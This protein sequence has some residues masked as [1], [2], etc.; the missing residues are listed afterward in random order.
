M[1]FIFLLLLMS[2]ASAQVTVKGGVVV[3]GG[4]SIS[5]SAAPNNPVVST[6]PQT[7]A[8]DKTCN[9]PGGVY[10]VTKTIP[11]SYPAT[12]A[13]INNS[14]YWQF[15]IDSSSQSGRCQYAYQMYRV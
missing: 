12:W 6:L 13:G 1:R 2:Y 9:P 4:V 15:F 8:N 10:D 5:S 7:W 11:G 14:D 3:S